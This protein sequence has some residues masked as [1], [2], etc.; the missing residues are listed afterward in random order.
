MKVSAHCFIVAGLAVEPPWAVN[1]GFIVGEQTTLVVDTGSTYLSAQTIF[2]YATHL[3]P[4]NR[5]MVVNTEPHFDHIGGNGYFKEKGIDILAAPGVRRTA[6]EFKRNQEEYNATIPN[7]V[8]RSRKEAE[9]FFYKTALANPTKAVVPNQEWDLGSAKVTIIESPGH[10]PFNI[11]LFVEPDRVLYCGDCI[12]T[13]YLP[14]L[15]A[16]NPEDWHTWLAS[17][18]V[19]D[20]L[21][22]E[23]VIPG[24]GVHLVGSK[25]IKTAI[26]SVKSVLTTALKTGK[27]P[28]QA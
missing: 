12:V 13:G 16:G 10:T 24:H 26:T 6:E 2:G 20:K 19:L 23:I 1:S 27:P 11:S 5:L 25:D 17:L 3:K 4:E 14:N 21:H 28:T 8:R 15:E 9:V 18:A 22:P 7:S